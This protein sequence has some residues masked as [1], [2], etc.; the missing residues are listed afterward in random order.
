MG[1]AQAELLY[2][3]KDLENGEL[4][5]PQDTHTL[6]TYMELGFL[7]QISLPT[8]LPFFPLYPLIDRMY[9]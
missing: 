5:K 1:N 3:T 8:N 2:P 4:K 6:L 9:I 7:F